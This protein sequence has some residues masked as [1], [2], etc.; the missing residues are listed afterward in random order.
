MTGVFPHP[1]FLAAAAGHGEQRAAIFFAQILLLV[2]VGRL[3]GEW[4]QRIG[5]PAVIGQLLAGIVLGPSVFGTIW[6]SVQ[7]AIFA[8]NASDRQMLNAVSELGVLL[9]LLLTGMETD[10]ALVRRV[11]RTASSLPQPESSF[12]L[13]AATSSGKCSQTA[14]CPIQ[15]A[16][17][18]F[19]L[20]RDGAVHFLRQNRGCCPPE[21]DIF[22]AILAR[23]SSQPR[24]WM[25]PSAGRF[26]RLSVAWRRREDC[27]RTG[28]L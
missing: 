6:P 12:H 21:V 5:Q 26:S 4:M 11:R 8:P 15:S 1:F 19:A 14:F 2:A 7:Q 28:A 25:T 20:P 18:H 16:L 13:P 24:S 9:L 22:V 23:S 10:L 17:A 3:L 27:N